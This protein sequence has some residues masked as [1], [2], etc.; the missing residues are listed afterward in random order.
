VSGLGD[1][2]VKRDILKY[3]LDPIEKEVFLWHWFG[4]CGL[5]LSEQNSLTDEHSSLAMFAVSVRHTTG[6]D[7]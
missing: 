1:R 4:C 5:K 3:V 2:K 7:I 6:F